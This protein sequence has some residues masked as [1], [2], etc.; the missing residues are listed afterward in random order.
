MCIDHSSYGITNDREM[1]ANEHRSLDGLSIPIPTEIVRLGGRRE[2]G[3]NE[4]HSNPY[5]EGRFH[6]STVSKVAVI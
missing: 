6:S 5:V 3:Q 2:K 4:N 1:W